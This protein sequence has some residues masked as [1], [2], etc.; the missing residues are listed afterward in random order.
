[1]VPF[2][3]CHHTLLL[4]STVHALACNK[5]GV[6]DLTT[7]KKCPGDEHAQLKLGL[8]SK[9]GNF[10]RYAV[11]QL[12]LTSGLVAGTRSNGSLFLFLSFSLPVP[13]FHCC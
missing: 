8:E 1:M 10:I 2:L 3:T 12:Q 13:A 9:R 5:G 6:G 4:T 7:C 11:I